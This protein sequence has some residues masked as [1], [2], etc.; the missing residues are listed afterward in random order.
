MSILATAQ[1]YRPLEAPNVNPVKAI[2]SAISKVFKNIIQKIQIKRS[3]YLQY[4]IDEIDKIQQPSI[5][6]M[7]N[8]EELTKNLDKVLK[9][10]GIKL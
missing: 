1:G 2:I 5:Q 6:N 3:N 4:K 10:L 8:R 9:K 7:A